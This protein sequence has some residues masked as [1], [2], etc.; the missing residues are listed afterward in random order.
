MQTGSQSTATVVLG[1]KTL[2][3]EAIA[4]QRAVRRARVRLA[5]VLLAM[6]F[7]GLVLIFAASSWISRNAAAEPGLT[8]FLLLAALLV[9][10]VYFTNNL[11]Q[12][13]ILRVH[14]LRC[15][16][17]E[18]PLGS[19]SHWTRRPGY[20]CPHCGKEAIATSRQLGDG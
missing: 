15:P 5:R 10:F 1:G 8:L 9:S 20:T 2:N 18:Q 11:W 6:L 13:R 14:D 7:I 19:E 4:A 17:C 12:W 16:H 3:A